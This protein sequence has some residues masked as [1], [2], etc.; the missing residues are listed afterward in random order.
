MRNFSPS[1]LNE[2]DGKVDFRIKA[3]L[4][5][6]LRTFDIQIDPTLVVVGKLGCVVFVLF[7]S[8]IGLTC[9]CSSFRRV[10]TRPVVEGQEDKG[11]Q[12]PLKLTLLK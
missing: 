11:N 12:M 1:I 5:T 4:F 9:V 2:A 6:M 7:L 8:L 3:F 10:V